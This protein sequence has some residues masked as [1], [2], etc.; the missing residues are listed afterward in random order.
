MKKAGGDDG[1]YEGGEPEN[2]IT[3]LVVD[4][5]EEEV[6][7]PKKFRI[8]Y[9][10]VADW[11]KSM[12]FFTAFWKGQLRKNDYQ[13][14]YSSTVSLIVLVI[15]AWLI[16]SAS[17]SY[18]GI[19]IIVPFAHYQL[20]AFSQMKTLSTDE[21]M[22]ILEYIC[23]ATAYVIQYGWGVANLYLTYG[24]FR[25]KTTDVTYP[26]PGTYVVVNL[27]VIP[28]I[29]SSVSSV[30]K[31]TDNK[32]KLDRFLIGQLV[33]T[34]IQG[35]A[36]LICAFIYMTYVQGA[37][38]SGIILILIYIGFQVYIYQK[39]DYYMPPFWSNINLLIAVISIIA[40]FVVS[41]CVPG[42]TVFLGFSISTWL[43][44]VLLFVF[45]F[46]RIML[47]YRN[48]KQKPVFFSPW[49]FPIYKFDPKKQD[50]VKHNLSAICMISSLVIMIAWSILATVWYTPIHVGVS[51]SIIFEVMLLLL[52]I[53]L[54][55][56]SQLQL[57]KLANL[58]DQKILRRAWI[59]AKVNYVGNR[60]AFCR[61]ELVTFEE[62]WQRKNLFR[63]KVRLVEGRA[64]LNLEETYEEV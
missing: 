29:T 20:A 59:E 11:R 9:K 57:K 25:K 56:I 38:I 24:F 21:P 49:V 1:I 51:L 5:D 47:D 44:S 32:G 31:W 27:I 14:I 58:I 28:F 17:K 34:L 62:Y 12:N 30:L 41:L 55:Q 63:N 53:F 13:I 10:E 60:S 7:N 36:M 39:N 42:F 33:M 50:V 22:N 52:V 23:F 2:E 15:G 43:L 16:S 3:E 61:Q 37:I 45:G 35:I 46:G 18:L 64:K 19:T 4:P 8:R 26:D 40:A 54:I 6:T 48:L